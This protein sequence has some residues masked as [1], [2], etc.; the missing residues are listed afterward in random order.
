MVGGQGDRHALGSARRGPLRGRVAGVVSSPLAAVGA[1]ALRAGPSSVPFAAASAEPRPAT[2]LATVITSAIE[3]PHDE[4][5]DQSA[6]PVD[7]RRPA[8]PP[9]AS[10]HSSPLPGSRLPH[11]G[12][13]VTPPHRVPRRDSGIIDGCPIRSC[14]RSLAWFDVHRRDL[15]WRAADRTPWAVLVSEVML[16]QTPVSRVLPVWRAWQER[17]PGP[18]DLAAAGHDEVLRAWG[19]LG[20]PRRALRLHACAVAVVERHGGELPSDEA[21]LRALPGVGEYTAAAVLAFANGR[22]SRGARHQRA[23]RAGAGAGRG[24]PARR[25]TWGPPSAPGRRRSCRRTTRRPRVGAPRSWSSARWCARRAPRPAHA[26][27]LAD[28]CAWLAEGRPPDALADAR[29]RQ[30]WHGTDRQARGAVMALL[31]AA[32]P[33]PSTVTTA[34]RGRLA[35]RRSARPGAGRAASRTGWSRRTA[36]GFRLPRGPAA[37]E[38]LMALAHPRAVAGLP[39]ACSRCPTPD[40]PGA[41]G[42]TRCRAALADLLSD[43]DLTPDGAADHGRCALVLPVR[44]ADGRAAALKLTW[45]HDEAEHEAPRLCS[46]GTGDG[47]VQLLRADP[48][49]WALLLER[50]ETRD[51]CGVDDDEACAIAAPAAPGLHR[52]AP[53]QLR[54]LSAAGRASGRERLAA[55][56]RSAPVPRRLVRAGGRPEPRPRPAT[57]RPTACWCTPT[58]TTPTCSPP[59]ASRGC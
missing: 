47:A 32:P 23:P 8:G 50:A 35:R 52:P 21:E 11:H 17:W 15:P 44:D 30:A 42:S 57:R 58:R 51:L 27:P 56:P 6:Q 29:R 1:V 37:G 36:A 16:Q 7:P 54:R 24:R 28:Q 53:P 43:W 13:S 49:R 9:G 26:C 4:H 12:T 38:R 19:R 41:S 14:R 45:P 20:Y 34:R 22:R 3:G 48:R 33:V 25:R 46:T 2:A 18:A 31:R 10:V 39:P 40:R 5:H 59:S 55:L